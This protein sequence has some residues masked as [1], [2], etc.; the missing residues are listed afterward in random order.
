MTGE[1][2]RTTGASRTAARCSRARP[3]TSCCSISTVS[4]AAPKN[5]VDDFPGEAR[6]YVRRATGYRAVIVN[7]EVALRDGQ[8]TAARNGRIV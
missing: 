5:F 6:R 3:P 8:Y 7:G 2:G 4:R 1:A